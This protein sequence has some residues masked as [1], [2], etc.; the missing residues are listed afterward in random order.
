[1]QSEND[2]GDDEDDDL[3]PVT[4]R[5]ASVLMPSSS[6]VTENRSRVL[7]PVN[8]ND[9]NSARRSGRPVPGLILGQRE[10]IDPKENNSQKLA[11]NR[12][13]TQLTGDSSDDGETMTPAVEKLKT[14]APDPKETAR[15][16]GY[17]PHLSPSFTE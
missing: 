8:A 9:P 1:M 13:R 15:G 6:P 17:P 4:P 16:G 11:S 7:A 12:G 5:G 10:N 3:V 2:D 14:R